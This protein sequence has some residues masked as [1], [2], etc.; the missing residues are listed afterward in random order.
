M[1]NVRFAVVKAKCRLQCDL[2]RPSCRRCSQRGLACSDYPTDEGFI[3]R[4]EN[5][6]AQRNSQ[7]ARRE[8]RDGRIL[9]ASFN[10]SPSCAY[11]EQLTPTSDDDLDQALQQQYQWLTARAFAEVPGPLKRDPEARAVDRFFVNWILYPSNR[12]ESPGYMHDL[13]M[14]YLGAPPE[15]VLWCAVRAVAFADMKDA[16]AGPSAFPIRARQ[17]YGAALARMRTVAGNEHELAQD[18]VLAALLL[19]D[20]FEAWNYYHTLSELGFA[21]RLLQLM[22]LARKEPFWPHSNAVKHVLHARGDQQFF[23]PSRFALWSVANHRLQARQ[24][25]LR[26]EPDPDQVVW[27]SKLNINR[28]DIHI[29]AD[30][31]HMNILVAAVKKLTE[32][33]EDISTPPLEK[34]EQARQLMNTIQSLLISVVSWTSAMTGVWKPQPVDSRH[35][36]HAVDDLSGYPIPV[37]PCPRVLTYHDIYLAYMWTFHAASQIVLRESLVGVIKYIAKLQR[38][39]PDPED[40]ERIRDQRYGVDRLAGAIIRS[41]PTLLG[42]TN[43]PLQEPRSFPRGRMAGRFF[44]LFSMWI[45]QRAEYTSLEHK[46]TASRVC[47]WIHSRHGLG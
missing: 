5:E 16:R 40:I 33:S 1:L 19:I 34:V 36:K 24:M 22:Y 35:Y 32:D 20:N 29:S 31:L 11:Q 14:L 17:H 13:P 15:S 45:V 41:I 47:E 28:P 26:E 27:L 46:D 2:A 21:D 42:I 7:R 12:G 39:E 23:D 6:A 3:F 25:L 9:A 30:V 4:D 38:Q 10:I 44:S 37:I 18:R 8:L 43:D